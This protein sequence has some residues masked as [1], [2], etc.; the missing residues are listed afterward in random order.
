MSILF[1]K[2]EIIAK[3]NF[4]DGSYKIGY[5]DENYSE[6]QIKLVSFDGD[7]ALYSKK[8]IHNIEYSG[9]DVKSALRKDSNT[10]TMISFGSARINGKGA[11][12]I[13]SFKYAFYTKKNKRVYNGFSISGFD[14]TKNHWYDPYREIK[15]LIGYSH[16]KYKNNSHKGFYYSID[17]GIQY[18]VACYGGGSTKKSLFGI[19]LAGILSATQE[20]SYYS[21][22]IE[23]IR[24][25]FGIGT[26]IT[27]GYSFQK[28][29]FSCSLS[30]SLSPESNDDLDIMDGRTN[31]SYY[32][33]INLSY[34]F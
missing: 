7:W 1:S 20:P 33:S 3:V 29:M 9:F 11:S 31:T 24:S 13:H 17:T 2:D 12:G 6:S 27:L 5:I 26:N 21:S 22:S 14:L 19:S 15:Y 10:T 25:P 18:S 16:L 34:L 8:S 23:A 28:I 4:K 30:H 32:S